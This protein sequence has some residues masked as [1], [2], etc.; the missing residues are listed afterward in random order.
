MEE[1]LNDDIPK[2]WPEKYLGLSWGKIAMIATLVIIA[3]VYI[4][5]LLFGDNSLEAYIQLQEYEEALKSEVV[6]IKEENALMQ[7]EYFELKEL[8]AKE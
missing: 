1:L 6:K 2:S 8:T 4:G 5:L 7:K 3:G